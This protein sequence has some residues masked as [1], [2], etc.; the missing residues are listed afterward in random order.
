ML[1]LIGDWEK[2]K[3]RRTYLKLWNGVEKSHEQND[4]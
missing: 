3:I 1:S 2:I 4:P